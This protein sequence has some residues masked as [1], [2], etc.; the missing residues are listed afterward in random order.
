MENNH[1]GLR[2]RKGTVAV[3]ALAIIAIFT[4]TMSCITVIVME[5]NRF[6]YNVKSVNESVAAKAKENLAVRV[7][8]SGD[9]TTFTVTNTGS[10]LSLIVGV[11]A[12]NPADNNPTYYKLS[13]PVSVGILGEKTFSI[14]HPIL[15]EWEVGVLTSLGNVF[16]KSQAAV[17]PP[18][19]PETRIRA[20]IDDKFD[21]DLG[22]WTYWGDSGYSLIHDIGAGQPAPSVGISGDG[23]VVSAGM[24]KAVDISSWTGT[25][26]LTL[27]FNWRAA[28]GYSGSTVTNAQLKIEDADSG[29]SLYTETLVAGGTTDTGWRSYSKDISTI[30]K[31][32]VSIRIVLYLG[33]GWIANWNQKNWYDNIR[34]TG[35]SV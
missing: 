24:Q 5:Y 29:V 22:G 32:H 2:F 17:Q 14:L 34:L 23:F 11:Y 28:S 35:L 25:G 12:V 31:G 9:E 4:I 21:L 1:L 20:F 19:L 15:D 26:E 6:A 3:G 33:D 16:W 10:T 13:Q 7:S 18:P 8:A 27:S 30:V